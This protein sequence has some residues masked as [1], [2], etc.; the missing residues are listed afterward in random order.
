MVFLGRVLLVAMVL[1]FCGHTADAQD[2][3]DLSVIA[4]VED[5]SDRLPL[6]LEVSVN[7]KPTNLVAEFALDPGTG[8]MFSSRSELEQLGL[9]PGRGLGGM[10]DLHAIPG[11]QFAYDETTQKI[12]LTVPL[13]A[14][15]T[16]VVSA[17]P[18]AELL[19]PERSYGAVL[20]Y[21]IA[22]DY[23]AGS[24]GSGITGTSASLDGWLFSPYGM[25]RST[26]VQR[27]LAGADDGQ[28]GVRL[29]TAYQ[30][31]SPK[32][33]LTFSVGDVQSSAFAWT[34]SI[35]MGGVQLRRDFGLRNDLVTQQL[36]SFDGAAA[37]PS[38][39]DVFIDNNRTYS[40]GREAG[41]FR[42]EDLPVRAGPGQALIVVTDEN[43]RRTAKAVSFYV[44]QKLLKKSL[45]DF[46]I[47]AG[48]AREAYG[49]E[50]NSYGDDG[51][52]SASLRYGLSERVTVEGNLQLK[53]DLT[54]I[55]LGL[56]TV[57]FN[58]AEMTLAAGAS[59]YDER[60]AGFAYGAVQTRLGNVDLGG[61]VRWS[62]A[63]FADLAYATGVDFLGED[64]ISD[65]SS[66]L[67]TPRLQVALN[68]SVPLRGG[69]SLGLGY[70]SSRRENSSDE[71]VTAA[72]SRDLPM[73]DGSFSI[74]GSHDLLTGDTR[75]AMG[76][77]V[78]LGKRKS[79][80]ASTSIDPSGGVVSGLYVSRAIS[81]RHGDYGY[82]GELQR[83]EAGGIRF[84]GRGQY[85][86]RYG[87]AEIDLRIDD[88][89]SGVRAQFDG[90]VVVAG[91]TVAL[92]NLV[93]DSFAIVDAGVAG[94]PVQVHNRPVAIT[95]RGG[96][97]LVTGLQSNRRNRVSV[98]MEHLPED[99]VLEATAMD[100][101]PALGSGVRV[102][103]SGQDD[104]SAVIILR[105][106]RGQEI[107]AGAVALVNG[108]EEEFFVGF[109]GETLVAG[110]RAQNRI[111]VQTETGTC[112]ADFAFTPQPEPMQVID[113][114]VCQ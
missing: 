1:A 43:G 69:A 51:L 67:E 65:T 74:Y 4:D 39:V 96:K 106:Y 56:T 41:P 32:R 61:S 105:D 12:D 58:L 3:S 108:S 85:L 34:R 107:E 10:V 23:Q 13:A 82:S 110:L 42:L 81:D 38:T 71:L 15:A 6:F 30:L 53:S 73:L 17:M 25:L 77:S 89:S 47:E 31:S 55:G 104:Q 97:V 86:G 114:V 80:S 50:S 111:R 112:I 22:T 28:Q 16:D 70:V 93:T 109:G 49:I 75:M 100:V 66:L 79:I 19:E 62:Q 102:R 35:R 26:G 24:F 48:R 18:E 98:D 33:R 60:T 113:G 29:E 94:V 101:V 84:S 103:L 46:S 8:R 9:R 52:L 63:G 54:L 20:N 68:L 92:G 11:L 36:L 88:G 21:S 72:Y 90:A 5:N 37:V 45:L 57:P 91:G 2:R 87:K 27:D 78:P 95:G 7:G 99:V 83:D 40:T 64:A 76:V 44:S 59:R 14:L